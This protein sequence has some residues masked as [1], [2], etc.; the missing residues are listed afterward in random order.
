MSGAGKVFGSSLLDFI[1]LTH[2]LL[3]LVAV[4]SFIYAEVCLCVLLVTSHV[5]GIS[6]SSQY[7]F[8][9]LPK[10]KVSRKSLIFLLSLP[11]S[12]NFLS[13]STFFTEK[14]LI[15]TTVF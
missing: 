10:K 12:L 13:Q 5:S 3:L 6:F 15:L 1:P 9:F 2:V 14:K 11:S 8:P 7:R 4:V